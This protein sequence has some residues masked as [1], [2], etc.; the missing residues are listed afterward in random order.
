M[1]LATGSRFI[2]HV[3][4]TSMAEMLCMVYA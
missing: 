2:P 3:A 1:F 4:S